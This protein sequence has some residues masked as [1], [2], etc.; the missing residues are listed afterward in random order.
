MFIYSIYQVAKVH[1]K[2]HI[3]II[4]YIFLLL[5]NLICHNTKNIFYRILVMNK[6]KL[7]YFLCLQR[8]SK[9]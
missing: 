8:Y 5:N 2:N 7:K 3:P 1:K 6:E 4:L 9:K